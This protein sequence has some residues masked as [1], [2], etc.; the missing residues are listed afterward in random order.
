MLLDNLQPMCNRTRLRM[1]DIRSVPLP[2]ILP[3]KDI[4]QLLVHM[5]ILIQI[6]A[7]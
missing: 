5:Q 4:L 7:V 6:R 2:I 3:D 1:Y